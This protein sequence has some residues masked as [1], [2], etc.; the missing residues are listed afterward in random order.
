[1]SKL[2]SSISFQEF[3]ERGCKNGINTYSVVAFMVNVRLVE[4][5]VK[6]KVGTVMVVNV[7]SQYNTPG[8]TRKQ[9]SI[10]WPSTPS[11]VL[12]DSASIE[13][14][15]VTVTVARLL[16]EAMTGVSELA[17]MLEPDVTAPARFS[18]TSV[19]AP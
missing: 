6:S 9:D 15:A 8:M 16:D 7:M 5:M 2:S 19:N 17:A 12:E 10:R 3:A 13:G 18:A 1:M 4:K 14:V 11:S